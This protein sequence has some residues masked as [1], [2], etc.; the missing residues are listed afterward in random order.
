M[1]KPA[2]D[3]LFNPGSMAIAGVSA[4]M[5]RP[6]PAQW[7]L[8]SLINFGFKG[9]VY[10]LHP[11]GGE[12]YG[13]KV[14]KNVQDI[15][16]EVDYVVSA[17]PARFTPQLIEDCGTKGVKAVHL[18]TSGYGEIEAEIG[19]QLE[20]EVLRI[21]R[22]T[23]VRLIGPNCMGLYC[24]ASGL[25]FAGDYP[26]QHGFPVRPGPLGLISQSGGNCIFCIR[27]ATV[28]GVFFSKAISYGNA[29]DLNE[30]DLLEYMTD[31]PDT[32]LIAMYIEGVKDGRRFMR[33]LKRAVSLKPVIINKAGNTETGARTCSSHTGAI[34]GSAGTWQGLL[35][36][37]GVTQVG[38]M[39]ELVDISVAFARM[40]V[41]AGR[42][43]AVVGSGGGVG[44]QAAD[45][46]TQAGLHLPVLP[47]D[48]REKL[49]NIYGTE[50]GAIFRNPV[51]VPPLASKEMYIKA[52]QAIADS[53]Q[54]DVIIMHFPFDL[55]AL[56]HRTILV[57][58]FTEVVS[59]LSQTI[60]KPLAIVLHYCVSANARKLADEVQEK[61]V[62][63]GLPVFPSIP[64][65]S[66]A[67][68]KYIQ[69]N[70]RHNVN[71]P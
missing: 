54:I 19:K 26:D 20:V 16:G 34:A 68:N 62:N 17:I 37:V 69:Y 10:P 52:V 56:A 25:T 22:R 66:Q 14:Y 32:K 65:A 45:E 48:I 58:P 5:A 61:I 50:A 43:V 15:P 42:N 64:R 2:L 60:R 53:D 28:R 24:P 71:K 4:D 39:S 38:S 67:I 13:M 8:K 59:E 11:A 7:F 27:E 23:G 51:D 46:I 21:A 41:P 49:H 47:S 29:V 3:Y 36:Q 30:C 31:D 55:W 70:E 35:R 6:S 33:A 44:V 57:A 12:I 40:P 9:R 1:P 18:F 63:L